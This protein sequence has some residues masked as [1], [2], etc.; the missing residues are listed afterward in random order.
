MV[1]AELAL[2]ASSSVSS[3]MATVLAVGTKKASALF[4]KRRRVDRSIDE[5]IEKSLEQQLEFLKREGISKED[6]QF[7]RDEIKRRR[8]EGNRDNDSR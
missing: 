5:A 2:F 8:E 4:F 7:I 1:E 3:L 6:Q